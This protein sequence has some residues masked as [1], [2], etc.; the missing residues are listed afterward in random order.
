LIE[1]RGDKVAVAVQ[2]PKPTETQLG[3]FDFE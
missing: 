1:K 3:L 2:A